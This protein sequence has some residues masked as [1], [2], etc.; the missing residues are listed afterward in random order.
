MMNLQNEITID[1]K[2]LK[3]AEQS[4]QAICASHD[5]SIKRKNKSLVYDC[6]SETH[7]NEMIVNLNNL[8]DAEQNILAFILTS[9]HHFLKIK[10]ELS[11]DDF[12]FEV[13]KIIFDNIHL[14]EK[15]FLDDDNL[16]PNRLNVLLRMFA[17]HLEENEN[18]S[19]ATTLNIL[20]Q[21]HRRE[22]EK[23]LEI[24]KFYASNKKDMCDGEVHVR[25]GII[26][27]AD[28]ITSFYFCNHRLMEV[29]TTNMAQL[30]IELCDNY[31]DT[32]REIAKLD[33]QDG[34]TQFEDQPYGS[35][36]DDVK[37]VHLKRH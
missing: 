14:L 32:M 4:L 2:L 9:H 23:D 12:T 8:R 21:A 25:N 35:K 29:S 30:P 18:L 22:V 27:S 7:N 15:I 28:D 17:E 6:T 24:V 20:T 31:D 36:G 3:E 37:V 5:N 10:D 1:P 11:V 33:L 19:S 34:F 13:H 16:L 26:E